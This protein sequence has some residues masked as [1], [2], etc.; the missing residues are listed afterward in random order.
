M[1]HA[2]SALYLFQFSFRYGDE[3]YLPYSAGIL[4][5]Y[6]QTFPEIAQ[7]FD[8]KQFV[9]VRE[10]PDAIVARLEEPAVAAFSTYVWNWEMSVAVA[11]RIRQ[12]YPDCLIVFGGPQV[13]DPDRLGNLFE[14]HPFIDVA[15]HG[16]GEHTFAEILKQHASTQDYLGIQ[17]LTY[18]GTTTAPRPRT[19]DLSALPSP[20]LTGVFDRLFDLPFK[21]QAV[22]E[23]NR[24][25]PYACTFCDWGSLTAQKLYTFPEE[26]LHREIEYFGEKRISHVYMADANFG[27][28]ARD[29]DLARR[30]AETKKRTGFP[31][32]LRVN[33][34]KSNPERVHEI[35]R[36]LNERQLDKGIT[37]SVQSMDDRTLR[38]I[39]RKNLEYETLSSFIKQYQRE[40]IST[41]TEVILGLP[42]E[43]YAT[44]KAGIETLLDASAHDSI[45]IYRCTVLPN[46]PMNDA[47]HR[48]EHGIRTVRTPI[49]L[50]HTEPGSDPVQEYEHTVLETATLPREDYDRCLL[51]AWA[52]QTFHALNLT[53][54]IALY[55]R[56]TQGLPATD[57]YEALL[58]FAA[59]HPETVVGRELAV[60]R[61]KVVSVFER[62]GSWD[63]V[64]PEFSNLTWAMEEAAY[65]RIMLE[66]RRFY[67]EL[68]LLLDDLERRGLCRIAPALRGDLLR[69]QEY[70]VVKHERDPSKTLTLSH[71][72]H[73][74][75]RGILGGET[76]PMRRGRFRLHLLNPQRYDGD[77][78]RYSTEVV[79][80]GRRGGKTIYQDI[81]EESL[82][83][84]PLSDDAVAAPPA[85]RS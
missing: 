31:S 84:A 4:W 12:R 25:C 10:Q 70:I 23:T 83:L 72:V 49:F 51:L 75:Y 16:E 42:G 85:Y 35:A 38:I 27:I 45:W 9:F 54:I 73:S 32:K 59:H 34:A 19:R 57:F 53:Q 6:A 58:D 11:R 65:L 29:A 82:D 79:F 77:L 36:I 55:A 43:T 14:T 37:L 40:G 7:R 67:S 63:S 68:D 3:I 46:A 28:L 81:R 2:R 41:Y 61:D 66:R 60:V 80:W 30:V 48:A 1:R 21:Y 71:S 33:Y 15:V 50:N 44:F 20:Y 18:R 64:V 62:G 78:G 26:R 17:G 5:A 22:W 47:A 52:V 56:A 74:F 8:N 69:Y 39:K 13:P 24:G 76:L